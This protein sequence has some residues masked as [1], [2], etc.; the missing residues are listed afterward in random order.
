MTIA[1]NII[2]LKKI[3]YAKFGN[4]TFFPWLKN[5]V[6]AVKLNHRVTN[7]PIS[8]KRAS[9]CNLAFGL[10]LPQPLR[11]AF[12]NSPSTLYTPDNSPETTFASVLTYNL[13]TPPGRGQVLLFTCFLRTLSTRRRCAVSIHWDKTFTHGLQQQFQAPL[14]S[15][16]EL[17]QSSLTLFSFFFSSQEPPCLLIF[18]S[19]CF[20][21]MLSSSCPSL[22][23]LMWKPVLQC[24]ASPP[25]NLTQTSLKIQVKYTLPQADFFDYFIWS[26]RCSTKLPF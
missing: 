14:P 19:H 12:L 21:N 10:I 25:W 24:L 13:Q 8:L 23:M 9:M 6:E 4:L 15:F 18:C 3:S 2:I 20:S 22:L 1:Q 11:L 26:H 16:W 7:T 5:S 17:S